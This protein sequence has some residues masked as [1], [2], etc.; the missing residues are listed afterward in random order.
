MVFG[1]P[2]RGGIVRNE[3]LD[4][5]RDDDATS[6]GR[7]LPLSPEVLGQPDARILGAGII[8]RCWTSMC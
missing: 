8:E 6:S 1:R 5:L 2:A 4:K 3:L 7:A